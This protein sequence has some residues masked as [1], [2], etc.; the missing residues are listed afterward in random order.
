MPNGN[1]KP[2]SPKDRA[3]GAELRTIRNAAGLSL[4]AVCQVLEWK[5]STLSRLERGLRSL[6]PETVTAL[7]VVYGL[8]GKRRDRLVA[9][10]KEVP[11]LGWWD[12]PTPGV[13]SDLGALASYENEATHRIDWSPGIVPGLLQSPAY[14]EAVMRE[15]GIPERD[16]PARVDAR[17]ARQR[18][19]L[20]GE[21]D[22]TALIGESAIRNPLCSGESLVTQLRH[23]VRLSQNARMSIRVVDQPTSQSMSGWYLM[24]FAQGRPVVHIEHFKS[25][26]YLFDEEATPYIS[27]K[28]AIEKVAL[29]AQDTRDML[30]REI[31]R[32]LGG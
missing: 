25:A 20:A 13:P 31:E 14:I 28:R 15:S 32:A 17:R 3:L 6:S 19:L 12:R 7:A 10:A 18:V 30:E 8:P 26:T 23:I 24:Q 9:W 5:E 16:I 22:Y 27:L 2:A 1:H 21:A 4:A 11:S 29:S